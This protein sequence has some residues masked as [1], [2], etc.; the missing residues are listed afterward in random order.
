[1]PKNILRGMG[2]QCGAT[3]GRKYVP[4]VI[5]YL[6]KLHKKYQ[7]EM[8]NNMYNLLPR[9][10]SS[11]TGSYFCR[12]YN[13]NKLLSQFCGLAQ[14]PVSTWV[15]ESTFVLTLSIFLTVIFLTYVNFIVLLL[16]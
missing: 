3:S 12:E 5:V 16:C 2:V 1:M 13:I 6:P 4:D 7:E 10:T 9:R 14:C 8:L 11:S 15:A